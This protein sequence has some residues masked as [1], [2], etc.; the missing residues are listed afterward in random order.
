MPSMAT[1]SAGHFRTQNGFL[2]PLISLSTLTRYDGH[3]TE[4]GRWKELGDLLSTSIAMSL[5]ASTEQH[6]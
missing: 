2:S 4:R 1:W 6:W 3:V 5:T